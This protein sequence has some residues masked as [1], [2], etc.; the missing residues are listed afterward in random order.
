MFRPEPKSILFTEPSFG[1]RYNTSIIDQE[2]K[3]RRARKLADRRK[4]KCTLKEGQDNE[5]RKLLR[6]RVSILKDRLTYN[7]PGGQVSGIIMGLAMY[8]CHVLQADKIANLSTK[9]RVAL[10]EEL[11]GI[12]RRARTFKVG[13][14][15]TAKVSVKE[16]DTLEAAIGKLGMGGRASVD[17]QETDSDWDWEDEDGDTDMEEV[18]T[19]LA[20]VEMRNC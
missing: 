6:T 14:L 2:E 20:E 3:E 5:I 16:M 4:K 13:R 1:G 9:T 8:Y 10:L 12:D 15:G 19:S 18:G 11:R 17:R 7:N